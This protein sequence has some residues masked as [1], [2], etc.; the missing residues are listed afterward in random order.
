MYTKLSL[1][2]IFFVGLST[3]MNAQF[4]K[5]GNWYYYPGVSAAT[6]KRA[7]TI[8][9]T[10]TAPTI[11]GE[12]DE[13]WNTVP[14]NPSQYYS[15]HEQT[16]APTFDDI[17]MEWKGLWDDNTYYLLIHVIDDVVIHDPNRICEDFSCGWWNMD[18]IELYGNPTNDDLPLNRDTPPNHWVKLFADA[19]GE[20][21]LVNHSAFSGYP[22]TAAIKIEQDAEGRNHIYYEYQD[23][24]WDTQL[25]G[26][27]PEVGGKMR[28]EMQA[29]DNDGAEEPLEE[30]T[31][32]LIVSWADSTDANDTGIGAAGFGEVTFGDETVLAGAVEFPAAGFQFRTGITDVNYK[33]QFIAPK[34]TTAPIIDG[35]FDEEVWNNTPWIP[36]QVVGPGNDVQEEAVPTFDDFFM[37]YKCVWDDETVYFL[38]HVADDVQSFKAD[39]NW[40]WQDALE[41]YVRG[42]GDA[43]EGFAR[44]NN[45]HTVWH[46]LHPSQERLSIVQGR[47]SYGAEI[48]LKVV[49]MGDDGLAHAYWEYKDIAWADML[50]GT[51][52]VPSVGDSIRYA[53]QANEDDDLPE[54]EDTER[55]YICQA[56]TTQGALSGQ[57]TWPIMIM[58]DENG[59]VGEGGGTSAAYTGVGFAAEIVGRAFEMP[60]PLVNSET[61]TFIDSREFGYVDLKLFDVAMSSGPDLQADSGMVFGIYAPAEGITPGD[62]GGLDI[63]GY[64]TKSNPDSAAWFTPIRFNGGPQ[65]WR[66]GGNWARY[67]LNFPSG[68]YN[69][70]YRADIRGFASSTH[71]FDMKIYLPNNLNNPVYST[72]I[73]LTDNFPG[74]PG[75]FTGEVIN[76]GGGNDL[77]DW[78][79]VLEIIPLEEG[80]YVVEIAQPYN[81]FTSSGVWG[82][83]TFN[84]ANEVPVVDVPYTGFGFA[85]S[86]PDSVWQMPMSRLINNQDTFL[87]PETIEVREFD[88]ASLDGPDLAQDTGIVFGI[89][90]P[91]PGQNPS[92]R[93]GQNTHGYNTTADTLTS[94]LYQPIRWNGGPLVWR[95]SGKWTRYTVNF[96]AGE[97]NYVYRGDVRGFTRN[98][99]RYNLKIYDPSNMVF[100]IY[101]RTI[102]L[103]SGFPENEGDIA[104]MVLNVG[105]GNNQTDWMRSLEPIFI[106]EAGNY[107]VEIDEGFASYAG[108][109]LGEIGFEAVSVSTNKVEIVDDLMKVYPNPTNGLVYIESLGDG[110]DGRM[111]VFALDGRLIGSRVRLNGEKQVIFDL[112]TVQDGVYLIRLVNDQAIQTAKVL[113]RN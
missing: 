35:E 62:T 39:G 94:P 50:V 85:G 32:D 74:T 24:P 42:K 97:F 92:D 102:D 18:G 11:D 52:M 91:G 3:P 15:T 83:F 113:V 41:F 106:P 86:T 1:V 54:D 44:N 36:Y 84:L 111:D 26:F 10:D 58:G 87:L 9:K 28:I 27:T 59:N 98:S 107:V 78:F 77:S 71:E 76:L 4:G 64:D 70:V 99:H 68:D 20:N 69:F 25:A 112:S 109:I 43:V 33:R 48:A 66:Q 95:G 80:D 19:S 46:V 82:E 108:S 37:E 55:E 79:R 47:D 22:A 29:Q 5:N 57:D 17:Y 7:T 89:Y 93:G 8:R 60:G 88:I 31:R 63:R 75:D 56:A 40:W 23:A 65:V 110:F 6:K 34:A 38:I 101:Q 53:I 104:D 72:T 2:F 49:E 100:P 96:P 45:T 81:P 16:T 51:G 103:T 105:G 21:V 30:L 73:D 12:I 61:G 13:V 14:W 67:T 90:P